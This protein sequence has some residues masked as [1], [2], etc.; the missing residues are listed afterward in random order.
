MT[1]RRKLQRSKMQILVKKFEGSS[2]S[3]R[4]FCEEHGIKE[5]NFSYWLRKYRKRESPKS[6]SPQIVPIQIEK[7]SSGVIKI[8]T[9]RG[10][11]I[12]IPI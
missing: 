5:S 3:R 11:Q 9:S 7:E 1:D 2:Q 12:H 8:V 6:S 4:V 10:V